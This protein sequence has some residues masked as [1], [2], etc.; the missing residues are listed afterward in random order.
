MITDTR[1]HGLANPEELTGMKLAFAT[2]PLPQGYLNRVVYQPLRDHGLAIRVQEAFGHGHLYTREGS[3][4]IFVPDPSIPSHLVIEALQTAGVDR[5]VT[6]A[7]EAEA[8]FAADRHAS[9]S[10][11]TTPELRGISKNCTTSDFRTAYLTV[12]RTVLQDPNYRNR[13]GAEL[14]EIF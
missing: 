11:W 4:L 10:L 3:D 2:T 7:I 13:V 14:P 9:G 5:V 12:L 1:F 8:A 6:E